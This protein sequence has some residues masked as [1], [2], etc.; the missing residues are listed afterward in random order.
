MLRQLAILLAAIVMV[1]GGVAASVS[2]AGNG[3][4][5]GGPPGRDPC[6]HGATGKPCRDDPQPEHG[7]DCDHHGKLGGVNEDHCKSPTTTTPTDTTPTDTTPTDTTPTTPTTP[8]GTTQTQTTPTTPTTTAPTATTPPAVV[9]PPVTSP[10]VTTAPTTTP[11]VAPPAKPKVRTSSTRKTFK[12]KPP[13]LTGDAKKDKCKPA[14]GNTLNCK[15]VIVV[16]GNG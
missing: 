6:S 4:P 2:L 1:A 8:T 9:P 7:K 14:P 16:P 11:P 3:P 10:A 5:S 12:A 15:G 13:K